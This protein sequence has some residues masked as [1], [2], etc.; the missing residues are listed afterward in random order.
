MTTVKK[1]KT[2]PTQMEATKVIIKYRWRLFLLTYLSLFSLSLLYFKLTPEIKSVLEILATSLLSILGMLFFYLWVDEDKKED[3]IEEQ[4]DSLKNLIY[5]MNYELGHIKGLVDNFHQQVVPWIYDSIRKE[6]RSSQ[7]RT[8]SYAALEALKQHS[9]G[10]TLESYRAIKVFIR[11]F[12]SCM[13][14]NNVYVNFPAPKF[15]F[16]FNDQLLNSVFNNFKQFDLPEFE[17]LRDRLLSLRHI[18]DV[19][20]TNSEYILWET[21]SQ[22]NLQIQKGIL[23]EYYNGVIYDMNKRETYLNACTCQYLFVHDFAENCINLLK[24]FLKNKKMKAFYS[25]EKGKLANI[26]ELLQ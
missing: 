15:T 26:H 22:N 7:F 11:S 19:Y 18:Y 13:Q 17:K 4:Y 2:N 24:T 9:S 8:E 1:Y 23:N 5:E 6:Q 16:N 14:R 21:P 20:R 25:K 3:Q 12:E 10:H